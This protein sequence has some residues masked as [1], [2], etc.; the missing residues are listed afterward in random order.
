MARHA[1]LFSVFLQFFFALP[2]LHL[3]FMLCTF[4]A[5]CP[6]RQKKLCFK[7]KDFLPTGDTK[8]KAA[9][10]AHVSHLP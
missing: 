1:S 7:M 8:S 2:Q 3:H 9:E 5:Q 4:L 6:R 10:D